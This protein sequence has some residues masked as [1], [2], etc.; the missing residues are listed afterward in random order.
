MRL[1]GGE[2]AGAVA[3]AVARSSYGKLVAYL[4]GRTGDVAAAEDALA[5]AFTAALGDWPAS[6]IP[7]KPEAWLM[8]VAQRRL[9]H[10]FQRQCAGGR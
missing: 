10:G 7:D 9:I 6:G 5:D 3:E 1:G 8:T 4:A 2:E